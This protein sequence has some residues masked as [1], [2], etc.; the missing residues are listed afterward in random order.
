MKRARL[1]HRSRF[2][3]LKNIAL[4]IGRLLYFTLKVMEKIDS[5]KAL[6]YIIL[7]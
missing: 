7:I 5:C 4:N 3:N 1:Y 6:I 2:T